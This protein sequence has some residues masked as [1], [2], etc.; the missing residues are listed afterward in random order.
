MKTPI[1]LVDKYHGILG[2]D[3]MYCAELLQTFWRSQLL[4]YS[5]QKKK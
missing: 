4:P 5:W 2:F 3:V 1:K